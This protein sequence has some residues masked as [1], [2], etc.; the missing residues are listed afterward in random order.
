[1]SEFSNLDRRLLSTYHYVET[2]SKEMTKHPEKV[3]SKQFNALTSELDSSTH[4]LLKALKGAV[5]PA[6][7]ETIIK[8]LLTDINS[9][10]K[11]S[12]TTKL[13]G[14]HQSHKEIFVSKLN[15]FQELLKKLRKLKKQGKDEQ[16]SSL[17]K[18]PVVKMVGIKKTIQSIPKG[19]EIDKQLAVA[20]AKLTKFSKETK[21]H[22]KPSLRACREVTTCL[23]KTNA[24]LEKAQ[25]FY[26]NFSGTQ[27]PDYSL[28][29]VRKLLSDVSKLKGEE[30][31]GE[32]EIGLDED[33]EMPLINKGENK[34]LQASLLANNPSMQ[35]MVGTA[36]KQLDLFWDILQEFQDLLQELERLKETR[37]KKTSL[38]EEQQ[39]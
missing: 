10:K 29:T 23:K 28:R 19:K 31:W 38:V 15:T 9:I 37:G 13:K 7:N 18:R 27:L 25:S 11:N 30:E 2:F 5:V 33:V 39:T 24:I 17:K 16:P 22:V 6:F 14:L 21:N 32:P 8:S 1:M 12:I 4:D 3:P 26:K 20:N 35:I 36:K 34:A